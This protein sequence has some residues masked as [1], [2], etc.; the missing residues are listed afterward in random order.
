M[1]PSG[2]GRG[3]DAGPVR[4]QVG[5][6]EER[7][8]PGAVA[9]QAL[10][11]VTTTSLYRSPRLDP[12]SARARRTVALAL[13]EAPRQA[14][15]DAA[16]Y[17]LLEDASPL[18]ALGPP[19]LALAVDVVL[20][21][22]IVDGHQVL[23]WSDGDHARLLFQGDHRIVYVQAEQASVI[24][25]NAPNGVGHCSLT[26]TPGDVLIMV[27]HATHA[28]LPLGTVAAMVREEATPQSLCLRATQAAAAADPLN[29][30]A[31]LALAVSG[32]GGSGR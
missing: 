19:G 9:Y 13:T 11:A 7:P 17:R 27:A 30:H 14:D 4:I 28:Q 21:G 24:R 2:P 32:Q 20:Q 12:R 10:A 1:V 18:L 5:L 26:L 25:P 6:H 31:M 22:A 16:H 23:L 8:C 3:S 15:A 29:H